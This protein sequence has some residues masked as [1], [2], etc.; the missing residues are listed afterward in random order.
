MNRI[1]DE[2]QHAWD[3]VH[4]VYNGQYTKFFGLYDTAA[5][6]SPYILDFLLHRVRLHAYQVLMA[7][8]RSSIPISYVQTSL[9]F[10]TI[11]ELHHFLQQRGTVFVSTPASVAS[12]DDNESNKSS[13]IFTTDKEHLLI[14]CRQS[15]LMLQ[16]RN[17]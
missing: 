1:S 15:Q 4:S 3:V 16:S 5:H 2:E 11:D 12:D 10:D 13:D 6:M 9:H 7:S 14:D 17:P 8:Y